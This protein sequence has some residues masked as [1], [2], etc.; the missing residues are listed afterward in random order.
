ML[1]GRNV[2]LSTAGGGALQVG[3]SSGR[4]REG[5]QE[6]LAGQR[7]PGW[8]GSGV[9][10]GRGWGSPPPS[11]RAWPKAGEPPERRQVSSCGGAGETE[12]QRWGAGRR[13]E[14]RKG[15]NR[16]KR[17]RRGEKERKSRKEGKE[18]GEE[19]RK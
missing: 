19:E 11:S 4:L 10:A 3:P 9:P 2:L 7:P 13:R 16:R 12:N 6:G 8:S 1:A 15:R 5:R 14:S 18:W 17:G